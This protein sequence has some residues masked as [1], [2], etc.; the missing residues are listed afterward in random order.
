MTTANNSNTHA[1]S[2]S[3]LTNTP[4]RNRQNEDIGTIEDFMINLDNGQI[5]YAVLSFGGF[6]GINDK[7]FAVPFSSLTIDTENEQFILDA[8]KEMLEKAPGFDKNNWPDASRT[9]HSEYVNEVNQYYGVE[10]PSNTN[11]AVNAY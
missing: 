6:L 4:V 2:T 1:L 3:S 11:T 7:L 8:N 10:R 5:D 9:R